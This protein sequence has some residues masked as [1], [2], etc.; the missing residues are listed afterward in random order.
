MI[1]ELAML[2]GSGGDI[3]KVTESGTAKLVYW[4]C[5][6]PASAATYVA[7]NIKFG[8][9]EVPVRALWQVFRTKGNLEFLC[10]YPA[11]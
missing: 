5:Q 11:C 9:K 8:S 4:F 7:N 2:C 10:Y 3:E 6:A 1:L